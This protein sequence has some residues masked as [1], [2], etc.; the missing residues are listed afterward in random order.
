MLTH[1]HR[2][3][4][5]RVVCWFFLFLFLFLFP[6]E[7]EKEKEKRTRADGGDDDKQQGRAQGPDDPRAEEADDVPPVPARGAVRLPL[8]K[9]EVGAAVPVVQSFLS[10]EF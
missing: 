10:F 6:K 4:N 9:V 1:E 3:L 5:R 8:F 2:R 7:K